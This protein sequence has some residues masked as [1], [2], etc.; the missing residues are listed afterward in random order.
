VTPLDSEAELKTEARRLVSL[1]HQPEI[2]WRKVS[3]TVGR[4]VELTS[5]L[6]VHEKTHAKTPRPEQVHIHG[7]VILSAAVEEALSALWKI[8]IPRKYATVCVV[9]GSAAKILATCRN[10]LPLWGF[11]RKPMP[12]HG[13]LPSGLLSEDATA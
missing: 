10:L 4:L 7:N 6:G 2:S 11:T 9:T 5:S 1:L 3:S 12:K 13:P 8:P